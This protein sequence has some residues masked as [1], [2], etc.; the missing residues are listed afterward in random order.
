VEA[1]VADEHPVCVVPVEEKDRG[2]ECGGGRAE[3]EAP[4]EQ[5][6]ASRQADGCKDREGGANRVQGVG[7]EGQ[8]L[9]QGIVEALGIRIER[10]A[11]A[12]GRRKP[13]NAEETVFLK[14]VVPVQKSGEEVGVV[15][16]ETTALRG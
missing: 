11:S 10:N 4:P 3:A 6:V 13:G 8:E 15:V 14:P 9:R 12:Q 7:D 1:E 16:S 5:G 2:A